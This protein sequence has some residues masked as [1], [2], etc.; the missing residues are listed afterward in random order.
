MVRGSKRFA[1][2]FVND[3]ALLQGLSGGEKQQN[4]FVVPQSSSL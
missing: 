1:P 4:R 2:T 3:A